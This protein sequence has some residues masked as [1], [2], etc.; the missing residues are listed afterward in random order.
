MGVGG[1]GGSPV[2]PNC[3]VVRKNATVNL[4][5]ILAPNTIPTHCPPL[6]SENATTHFQQPPKLR[7]T[8]LP[9]SIRIL[10]NL[11][12]HAIFLRTQQN[13]DPKFY[14]KVTEIRLCFSFFQLILFYQSYMVCVEN[15]KSDPF[16][17][18]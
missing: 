13:Q 5:Y 11:S 18:I 7:T 3:P 2:D 1:G 9:S 4:A 16:R 6:P 10:G 17:W 15:I 14:N 8:G 12:F